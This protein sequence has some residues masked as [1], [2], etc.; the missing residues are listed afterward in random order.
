MTGIP[1]QFGAAKAA[2]SR[3][4]PG[5]SKRLPFPAGNFIVGVAT[6]KVSARRYH[7]PGLCVPNTVGETHGFRHHVATRRACMG[8]TV[9]C[10][11]PLFPRKE[12]PQPAAAQR[13]GMPPDA[14]MRN[15]EREACC[16]SRLRKSVNP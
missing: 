9:F 5:T 8:V 11:R 14:T 10:T 12:H 1:G 15:R 4:T 13:D 7:E 16:A 2:A 6:P 3:R